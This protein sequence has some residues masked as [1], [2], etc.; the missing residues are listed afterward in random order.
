MM[1]AKTLVKNVMRKIVSV[2]SRASV[3]TAC[4]MMI[5]RKIGSIVVS[6][7]GK[8]IGIVTERDVVNSVSKNPDL[9]GIIVSD[10]MSKPLI[11]VRANTDL[12]SAGRAMTERGIRRLLV[13]EDERIVG[14]ISQKDIIAELAAEEI[15]G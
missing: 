2:D 14:L 4:R 6:E 1:L 12:I 3:N 9:T 5:E 13:V 11:T 10:I 15:P 8:P 7:N